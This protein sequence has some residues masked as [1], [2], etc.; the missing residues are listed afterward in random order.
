VPFFIARNVLKVMAARH[1]K[2]NWMEGKPLTDESLPA[3]GGTE[4]ILKLRSD[5]GTKSWLMK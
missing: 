5:G 2:Q 3:Y 4:A 1:L